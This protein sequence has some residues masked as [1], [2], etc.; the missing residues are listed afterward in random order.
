MLGKVSLM[1]GVAA[2]LGV[3]PVQTADAGMRFRANVSY[4]SGMQDLLDQY[5][6]NIE[7]EYGLD[8]DSS[9]LWPVGISIFPYYQW[10]NGLMLGGTVGPFMYIYGEVSGY[11]GF[12]DIDETYT[13]WQI[14]LSATIGYVF[15]PEGAVSPYVRGGLSYHVAGGD[16]YEGSSIGPLGAVGVE[17]LKSDHF[18][19]GIEAAYDGAEVD[20][21]DYRTGHDKS[22]KAAEFSLGVFF[23]FM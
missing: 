2:L 16:F 9:F 5:E 15:N 7:A 11:G 1:V 3:V 23:Q 6:D 20:I 17:F 13:H 10:D 14:P 18:R 12:E 4:V 22:I 19:I 21:E 8:F